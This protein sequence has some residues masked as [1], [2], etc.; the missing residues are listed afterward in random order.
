MEHHGGMVTTVL[1]S[2][3]FSMTLSSSKLTLSSIQ[4]LVGPMVVH[5]PK[6]T[7]YDIDIGPVMLSDHF[8]TYYLDLIEQVYHASEFGPILPPMAT[9]ML[10]QGKVR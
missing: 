10:I 4:G 2:K 7:D 5:G 1:N 3:R 6:S 9:N 8:H